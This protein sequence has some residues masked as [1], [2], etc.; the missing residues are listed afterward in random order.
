[1]SQ[2]IFG[3]S[4]RVLYVHR[5]PSLFRCLSVAHKSTSVVNALVCARTRRL[6]CV[7]VQTPLVDAIS[8]RV[9]D[10]DT[11]ESWQY[12][13]AYRLPPR[14]LPTTAAVVGCRT[15]YQAMERDRGEPLRRS[16]WHA[17]HRETVQSSVGAV[18]YST[19]RMIKGLAYIR[20]SSVRGTPSRHSSL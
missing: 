15:W 16:Y 8:K 5:Y 14:S 13:C 9:S 4:A 1:M 11:C 6:P 12:K 10:M 2:L 17:P 3:K 19:D 20:Q 18:V 7:C